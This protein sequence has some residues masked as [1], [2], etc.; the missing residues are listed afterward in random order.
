VQ[1]SYNTV[2]SGCFI[3]YCLLFEFV[4][5]DLNI[6]QGDG[7]NEKCNG[8][9]PIL[10]EEIAFPQQIVQRAGKCQE[11]QSLSLSEKGRYVTFIGRIKENSSNLRKIHS[12]MA[13]GWAAVMGVDSRFVWALSGDLKY[14]LSMLGHAGASCTYPCMTCVRGRRAMGLR[15][16]I[17]AELA[18]IKAMFP[19]AFKG[20]SQLRSYPADKNCEH[21]VEQGE[22]FCIDKGAE[23]IQDHIN[24]RVR[25]SFGGS[26]W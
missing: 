21:N 5:C 8:G 17:P 24:T 13:A 26:S 25:N 10:H 14:M 23:F 4:C 15:S 11:L 19:K 6:R 16:W 2:Y 7:T 12:H 3:I 9:Q 20:D 22:C 18:M 1:L